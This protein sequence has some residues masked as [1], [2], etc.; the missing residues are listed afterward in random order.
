MLHGLGYASWEAH[1]LR[2]EFGEG[3]WS[4]DNRGTGHSDAFERQCSIDQLAEDAAVAIDDLRERVIVIGHSMGGY[5]AQ[6]LAQKHPDAVAG[7][8]L[9]GTS[10][11]GPRSEPVPTSTV[12][13]WQ[14][15][16]GGTAADYARRTMPLSFRPG[17]TH[18]HRELFEQLLA[19]RLTHPTPQSTWRAQF[20]ACQEFLAKGIA[21]GSI[22]VPALVIHGS[23][24]RV[25][26]VGNGRLLA[27]E[28]P[29]ARYYEVAD[30]GHLVHLEEP[31]LV[32]DLIWTFTT[33][34]T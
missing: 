31:V 29:V 5:I 2:R 11:G 25:V 23:A 24:D 14:E 15:A 9:M 34:H 22:S 27:A 26:P 32:A 6:R 4:L 12:E 10:P 33:E 21:P 18:E 13:A 20:D 30:A 19:A 16:A 1:S 17:W 28:L 8:V 3:L 7:L